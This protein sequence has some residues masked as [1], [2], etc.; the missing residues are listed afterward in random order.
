MFRV[1]KGK[2]T[3]K[4]KELAEIVG[5]PPAT[6]YTW[7]EK[8]WIPVDPNSGKRILKLRMDLVREI[9]VLTNK[10]YPV[11]WECMKEYICSLKDSFENVLERKGRG[12]VITEIRRI[13]ER[14][15]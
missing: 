4:V 9:S 12:K 15:K 1:K 7:I 10:K 2:R 11:V 13:I 8:G 14:K 6:I 3:Y 5:H